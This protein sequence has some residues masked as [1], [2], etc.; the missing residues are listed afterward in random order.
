MLA[1]EKLQNTSC[2]IGPKM[3][4][5]I[6]G[7]SRSRKDQSLSELAKNSQAAKKN[8]ARN[9]GFATEK[10]WID[11]RLAYRRIVFRMIRSIEL[12]CDDVICLAQN[13]L[14]LTQD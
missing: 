14:Q 10:A 9:G 12:H 2:R 13:Y 8:L 7:T 4:Q 3:D 1:L 6:S 11:A 5:T